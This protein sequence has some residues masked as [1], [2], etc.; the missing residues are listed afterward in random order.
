MA[1][2]THG[3]RL[4]GGTVPL[5]REPGASPTGHPPAQE[6]GRLGQQEEEGAEAQ[7]ESAAVAQESQAHAQGHGRQGGPAA[8]EVRSGNRV[9]GQSVYF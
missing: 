8:K 1:R 7:E 6:E 4:E 5:E 9:P 3:A 2:G